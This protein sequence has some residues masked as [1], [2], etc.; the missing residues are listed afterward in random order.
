LLGFVL[1]LCSFFALVVTIGESWYEYLQ[2]KWVETTAQIHECRLE[3]NRGA[4][5]S[6]VNIGCRID[7]RVG[8]EDIVIKVSSRATR[9]G[10]SQA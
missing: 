8:G 7:F 10:R 1:G 9:P 4:N 3:T 5:Q 6:T 2:S